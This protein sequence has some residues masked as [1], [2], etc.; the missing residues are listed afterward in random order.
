M[1]VDYRE[2]FVV[3]L[4]KGKKKLDAKMRKSERTRLTEGAN[5]GTLDG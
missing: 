4:P 3:T 2:H 5:S 1:V